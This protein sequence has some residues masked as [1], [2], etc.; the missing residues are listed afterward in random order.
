MSTIYNIH[1]IYY[2]YTHTY[3]YTRMDICIK[4]TI[5]SHFQSPYTPFCYYNP[6]SMVFLVNIFRGIQNIANSDYQLRYVSHY[7]SLSAW[8]NSAPTGQIC[9][10]F[11]T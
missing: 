2:I 3:A 5:L 4:D 1:V 6:S 7:V 10:K 9:V 11:N 8:N